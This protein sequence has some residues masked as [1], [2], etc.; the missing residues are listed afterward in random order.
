MKVIS[1]QLG[2][3]TTTITR[4]L[5]QHVRQAVLDD[6]AEK[7]AAFLPARGESAQARS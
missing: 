5:Y 2:R 3:S 1:V 4:D 7:I 6:A